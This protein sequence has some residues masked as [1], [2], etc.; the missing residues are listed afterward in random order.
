MSKRTKQGKC[1]SG[2]FKRVNYFH[3][4]LLTEQDFQDE[5]AYLREKL[6]LHNRLHGYGVVWGLTLKAKC[7]QA[8]GQPK[9]KIFLEPGFALDCNGNEIIVCQEQLVPLDEKIATISRGCQAVPNRL[10]VALRFC[11][12]HSDPETQYTSQCAG[13][14]LQPQFSR[15]REGFHIHVFTKQEVAKILAGKS[16]TETPQA[17]DCCHSLAVNT[18]HGLRGCCEED[19][20][21]FVGCVENFLT[22]GTVIGDPVDLKYNDEHI[23]RQFRVKSAKPCHTALQIMGDDWEYVKWKALIFA[24]QKH[25]RIDFSGVVG[26]TDTEAQTYLGSIKL[27]D[28]PSIKAIE[29]YDFEDLVKKIKGTFPYAPENSQIELITDKKKS[30]TDPRIANGNGAGNNNE[31]QPIVLYAFYE[32]A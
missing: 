25:K 10:F 3:G 20:I 8:D 1:T 4:M 26:K 31:E 24:A 30:S 16:S 7:I 13:D 17:D 12:C 28:R 32:G 22:P 11:E 14:M 18:C 2:K 19:N 21:V 9:H 15:V 23:N 27:S 6:K 5:Q 29:E